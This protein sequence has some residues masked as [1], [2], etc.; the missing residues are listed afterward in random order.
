MGSVFEGRHQRIG[1]RV[2]L[3]FLHAELTENPEIVTRFL[4]EALDRFLEQNEPMDAFAQVE[5]V[6]WQMNEGS[7][8]G[9]G[10]TAPLPLTSAMRWF[11]ED[12]Q[13]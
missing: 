2:A 4:R 1:R 12:F 9:L 6:A 7:I 5:D 3:K 11:P 8:C 10:Q 13:S